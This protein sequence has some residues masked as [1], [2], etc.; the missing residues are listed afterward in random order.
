MKR[1][2]VTPAVFILCVCVLLG[3]G[4][5]KEKRG[6]WFGQTV[7]KQET[8]ERL[9][10]LFG[11]EERE[12]AWISPDTYYRTYRKNGVKV[13]EYSLLCCEYRYVPVLREG[14]TVWRM[15]LNKERVV[16]R[17]GVREE[18]SSGG[19]EYPELTLEMRCGKNSEF[20]EVLAKAGTKLQEERDSIF[21]Q[22]VS[23]RFPDASGILLGKLRWIRT[24]G[25]GK[26]DRFLLRYREPDVCGRRRWI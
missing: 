13:E 1:N 3:A 14:Y 7:E 4:V 16:Y 23:Y 24:N 5:W 19:Y 20:S 6:E 2:R 25:V 15:V 21:F 8:T 10:D 12:N 22:N 11:V 26:E 9:L 18:S 17:G